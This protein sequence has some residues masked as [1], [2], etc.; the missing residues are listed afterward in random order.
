MYLL[1]FPSS[2]FSPDWLL[3]PLGLWLE[4]RWGTGGVWEHLGRNK[5][6]VLLHF[7][8]NLSE[9]E[10]HLGESGSSV[11]QF[12]IFK[13]QLSYK[14]E[15]VSKG[16]LNCPKWIFILLNKARRV[17]LDASVW[18]HRS[19]CFACSSA[20]ADMQSFL[21]LNV[22]PKLLPLRSFRGCFWFSLTL[23]VHVFRRKSDW[24]VQVNAVNRAGY[25]DCSSCGTWRSPRAGES[26]TADCHVILTLGRDVQCMLQKHT[27]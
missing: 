11:S 8:G 24:T 16:T 5:K 3:A 14:W 25:T 2:Q 20:S 15:T 1:I 27:Q 12:L 23:M 13:R 22:F 19:S 9:D 7:Y 10:A 26:K 17:C 18:V 6:N 21:L 4:E